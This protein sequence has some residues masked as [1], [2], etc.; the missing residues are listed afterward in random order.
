MQKIV[1]FPARGHPQ[2]DSMRMLTA[3]QAARETGVSYG[4]MLEV[5]R[6][7][8]VRIGRIYYM[9]ADKLRQLFAGGCEM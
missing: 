8:G 7:H 9:P 3:R 1:Q 2:E 4:H 5:Y 6:V